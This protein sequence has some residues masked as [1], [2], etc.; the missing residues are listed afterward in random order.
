M[1]MHIFRL[2]KGNDLLNSIKSFCE[3]NNILAGTILS[4][5][6]CVYHAKIRDAGGKAIIEINEP[7]EIISLNGTVSKH[8]CHLHISFAKTDL[9]VVGGHLV[10]GCLINTT[11][12]IILLELDDYKFSKEF[13]KATGYNELKISRKTH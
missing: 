3:Q 7:L 2:T 12:E 6:G 11:C 10:E 1:K 13:D 9:S 8:R 5:V 4:S